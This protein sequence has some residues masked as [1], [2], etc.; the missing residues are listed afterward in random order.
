M[1]ETANIIGCSKDTVFR[2]LKL[3]NIDKNV[4]SI[5]YDK[6]CINRPIKVSQYNLNGEFIRKFNSVA[7]A[8]R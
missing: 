8:A 5:D 4:V 1:K 6:S 7:D 2:I 3:H